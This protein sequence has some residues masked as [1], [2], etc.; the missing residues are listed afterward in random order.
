MK[1]KN[2]KCLLAAAVLCVTGCSGFLDEQSYSKRVQNQF[3][4]NVEELEAGLLGVYAKTHVLF[5]GSGFIITNV[6]TDELYAVNASSAAGIADR[7]QFPADHPSTTNW[8]KNHYDVIEAANIIIDV[9]PKVPDISEEDMNRA[10]AEAKVIR[11]WC[12][13][14]LVQTFGPLVLNLTPT[15][16]V[17]FR[18][19]RKPIQEVYDVI[20]DDLKFASSEGVLTKDVVTG[21]INSYVAKGLLAKVYLTLATSMKRNPQPV[22]EYSTLTYDTQ[23]LLSD[24]KALCDEIIKYG[25]YSLQKKYG[26]IFMLNNKNNSE[27]LW[28]IQFSSQPGLG[29]GW[30]KNFG[31]Q[32]SGNNAAA[33]VSCVVGNSQYAP[34][35]SFY[36]SFKLGDTRRTWSIADYRVAYSKSG[37]VERI[38]SIEGE[39]IDDLG[40][41]TCDLNCDDEYLLNAS[42]LSTPA[43]RLRVS[44]YRWSYGDDPDHFYLETME[45]ESKNAPNNV[46]VLRYADILLMRV[47]TDILLNGTADAES[48]GYM[49][50]LVERARGWNDAT[51][52]F[53]TYDEMKD[54]VF[55]KYRQLVA[56]AQTKF[57][58]AQA[59]YDEEPTDDNLEQLNRAKENLEYAQT[60]LDAKGGRLLEDYDASTLTYDEVLA[61]RGYELC[62]EFHRWF[63]LCRTGRLKSAIDG[64]IINALTAPKFDLRPDVHYLLPIP[65]YELD[66]AED[67]TLFYQNYGY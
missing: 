24:S 46:I 6:G 54:M 7:Y 1:L 62:F 30:S 52:D 12:Y 15:N 4:R 37:E 34:L 44:K 13:F 60:E 45:F 47:E 59:A 58:E 8:Y 43:T 51:N 22:P 28:E 27:S 23:K 56:D 57:D 21:R 11:A 25:P 65:T 10:V 18:L 38:N 33:S 63:D 32:Q 14:R 67:K 19:E 48:V 36:R 29:S 61:Q 2:I 16:D 39:S 31:V 5:E 66:L 50:M 17:N 3:Y 53:Y 55:E 26:S 42:L 41:L 20:I 9:A 40:E 49:N 64:R 35:P